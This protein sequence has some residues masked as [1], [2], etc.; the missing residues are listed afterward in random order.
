MGDVEALL[1]AV[2]RRALVERPA[3]L[4]ELAALVER[5]TLGAEARTLLARWLVDDGRVA[6]ARHVLGVLETEDIVAARIERVFLAYRLGETVATDEITELDRLVDDRPLGDRARLSLA[7]GKLASDAGDLESARAWLLSAL[8]AGRRSADDELVAAAYGALGEVLYL[9]G[10]PSAAIDAFSLDQALLPRG[11][12]ERERLV[13]Y[14]AHAFRASG[15]LEVARSL[16]HEARTLASLRGARPDWALRGLVWCSAREALALPGMSQGVRDAMG[17]LESLDDAD[18]HCLAHARAALAIVARAEGDDGRA[19]ELVRLASEGFRDAG[20][21]VEAGTIEG[22]ASE[23][24]V[25]PRP[26]E[27]HV[28][29]CDRGWLAEPLESRID[30]LARAATAVRGGRDVAALD[31]YAAAFF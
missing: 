3:A 22:R 2:R 31:A 7:V 26:R 18:A 19:S 21:A 9:G 30:S 14:R 27:L 4:Q 24:R 20:Y 15:Q 6:E 11:S 25:H 17:R 5:G 28:D 23:V 8:Y 1:E 16:Y 10:R 13:T 12:G 29:A